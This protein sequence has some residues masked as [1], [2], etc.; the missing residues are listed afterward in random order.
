MQNAELVPIAARSRT[1]CANTAL[2]MATPSS[3]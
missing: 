3:I 2:Q 1:P